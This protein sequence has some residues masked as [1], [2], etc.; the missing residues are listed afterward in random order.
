MN[1]ILIFLFILLPYIV[2]CQVESDKK[3]DCK[4]CQNALSILKAKYKYSGKEKDS[5]T[6]IIEQLKEANLRANYDDFNS[7]LRSI[8]REKQVMDT[9]LN[10]LENE[11]EKLTYKL[12][13]AN[14]EIRQNK[15]HIYI[16]EQDARNNEVIINELKVNIG[17]KQDEI[18]YLQSVLNCIKEFNYNKEKTI[19]N[20]NQK[21]SEAREKY[22]LFREK[23]KLG[24]VQKDLE[25]EI[26]EIVKK[27]EDFKQNKFEDTCY[28]IVLNFVSDN[29]K[30]I[31]HYNIA[32]IYGYN[33]GRAINN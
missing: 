23:R 30:A 31:D 32:V 3:T 14:K 24:K 6:Y 13:I 1:N 18:D 28:G 29:M 17:I 12:N 4:Y 19:K 33:Q 20:S 5:L 21:I 10:S 25:A 27:Y 15:S 7:Q 11:N 8:E 9:K 22:D 26:T 16:L 2:N